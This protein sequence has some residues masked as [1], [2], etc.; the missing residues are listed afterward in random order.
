M[1]VATV[2]TQLGA[3]RFVLV[4]PL[5]SGNIG[6]V[7]RAMKNMGIDDLAVVAPRA[8]DIDRAR[9]MAP[10]ATD[11]VD[12]AMY[13]ATVAEAVAD[14]RKVYATTAR[15]RHN[16]W[17]AFEPD[18]FAHDALTYLEAPPDGA[19][20]GGAPDG[21]APGDG[22]SGHRAAFGAARVAVLFGP[23][24]AGLGNESLVHAHALIHIPTDAHASLNLA[25]AALL[26][27]TALFNAV[28]ANGL[29]ARTPG[30]GKRGG[31]QRGAPPGASPPPAPAP[32]GAIEP[33]VLEWMESL[34]QSSYL[35]G[36]E[37]VLVEG[38]LRRILQRATLDHQELSVLRG[39]LRKMRWKMG[40]PG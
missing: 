11:V 2:E 24:D 35:R 8:L 26:V 12:R 27:G 29:V 23:E 31:L 16:R 40:E 15:D 13:C 38:T 33:L 32:M 17:P 37:T 19:P 10:N 39:M 36:H 34:D 21:G 28:R 5:Q 9:W 20:D 1:A 7:A 25:Q 18:G 3:V 14:C 22:A 4:R 6:A 30:H